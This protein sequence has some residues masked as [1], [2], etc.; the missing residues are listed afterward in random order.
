LPDVRYQRLGLKGKNGGTRR[1]SPALSHKLSNSVIS[2]EVVVAFGCESGPLI[3]LAK[4][5]LF[6]KFIGLS[7]GRLAG[8][9]LA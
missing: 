8:V 3:P 6:A 5:Q 1:P 4:P 2:A 9:A 7:D